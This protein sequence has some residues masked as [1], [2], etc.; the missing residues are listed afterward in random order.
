M[1]KYGHGEAGKGDQRRPAAV[2]DAEFAE[3][4]DRAF[5]KPKP[6]RSMD[7]VQPT[8]PNDRV[9]GSFLCAHCGEW[10]W[11]YVGETRCPLC[12]AEVR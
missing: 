11:W 7:R 9:G 3:N 10:A 8:G 6:E 5:F 1:S 2:S 12:G 4:W